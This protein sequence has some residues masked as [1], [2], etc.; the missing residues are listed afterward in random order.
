MPVIDPG[1]LKQIASVPVHN[2]EDAH[3]AV[4]TCERGLEE[5]SLKTAKERGEVL[6]RI[7]ELMLFHKEDLAHLITVECGK[8]LSEALGEVDYAASFFKWF[9]AEGRRTYGNTIPS[10]HPSKRLMTIKQ[11]VGVCAAITPW[12]FPSAM[13]TRKLAPALAAGCTMVVKPAEDTPLSAIAIYNLALE[14]GLPSNAMQVVTSDRKGSIQIGEALCESQV[15]RKLS[16]TGSTAVGKI[17]AKQSASTVKRLSLELGGNAP[18]IVFPDAD[19]NAAADG[20]LASKFRNSGQTCVCTNRM[21]VH[22]KVHDAFVE[23]LAKRVNKLVV[24]HGLDAGVTQGPLINEA[25]FNKTLRHIKNAQKHG[26][27]LITGGK[28]M[29]ELGGYFI[30]PAIITNGTQDMEFNYEET[31]GPIAGIT[32]FQH[33]DEVI[34]WSNDTSAGL[35][36]YIFTR[37]IHRTF[38][39]TEKLQYGMVAVNDGILSVESAPF[40]GIKESG[41]GREGGSEGIDEY[42]NTKY[43][44]L[45]GY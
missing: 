4:Q 43:I 37:D 10:N 34:T 15:V 12:N 23:A 44:C 22:E 21:Y 19:I 33:E 30:E 39:V 31:F 40:G 25:G 13:I 8:P 26:A 7:Y 9:A 1:N 24:G 38:R 36:A 6:E 11:P 20:A 32:T 14:A 2:R 5:W 3:K 42:L 16:F 18:L 45:G 29:K 27:T 17:L 41:I 35:A 28:P